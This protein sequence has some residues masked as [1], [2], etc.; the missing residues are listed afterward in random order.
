MINNQSTMWLVNKSFEGKHFVC[1]LYFFPLVPFF[2]GCLHVKFHPGMKLVRGWIISVYG[3]MSLTVYTFLP[4]W[5][6]IPGWTELIPGWKTGMKFHPGMKKRQKRRV[7]TSSRDE[8]LKSAC[9]LIFDICI[10]VCF[11]N[12]TSLNI[13]V[14]I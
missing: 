13:K 4:R 6:F 2:R 10:Q 14:W 7:N 1:D 9:F 12:S 8:I 11:P 3:E 5:N